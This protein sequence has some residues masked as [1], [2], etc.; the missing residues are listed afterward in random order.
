MMLRC[1]CNRSW[2]CGFCKL[3]ERKI[4][5]IEQQHDV[6]I[7]RDTYIKAWEDFLTGMERA[8][9]EMLREQ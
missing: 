1:T 9:C 4:E 7:G 8:Y 3:V 5:E 2:E 6:S